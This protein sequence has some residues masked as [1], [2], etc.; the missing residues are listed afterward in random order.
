[1]MRFAIALLLV[2]GATAPAMADVFALTN[3]RV[4]T[5]DALG[6]LEDAT[7]LVRNGR[8]ASVG[9]DVR[10]PSDAVR[11][12]AAG[13]EVT[14]GLFAGFTNLG[15]Q[16]ISAVPETVDQSLEDFDRGAGFSIRRAVNP[17]SMLIG[18]ARTGGVTRAMIGPSGGSQVFAGQASLIRLDGASNPV[19]HPDHAQ[20]A[21]LGSRGGQRTGG[22]RAAALQQLEQGFAEALLYADSRALIRGAQASSLGFSR[23]D[24]DALLA[25]IGS[26]RPMA[27]HADRASDIIQALD[28][29]KARGI[30][31]VLLGGAEAWKV[32]AALAAAD[33]P[34]LLDPLDNLPRGFDRLGARS[35]NITL[36]HQAGVSV[37][38]LEGSGRDVRRIRQ[39]AG[40]AVAEGLPPE[41]A[42]A[43]ITRIPAEVWG[44]GDTYGRIAPGMSADLVLWN[45]DPLE[46]TTW[47]QRVWIEGREVPVDS[48]QLQLRDRYREPRS[49]Y[50]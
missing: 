16:E 27:V 28:I 19:S 23:W 6:T 4:H 7:V 8:I 25:F 13:G 33:V 24:L 17:D 40:N 29:L 12:D 5:V 18:V 35:D 44:V 42:L 20:V 46:L 11:I 10:I 22:S 37:G 38:I 32:A 39:Y 41:V 9:K 14:P 15:I 21:V 2:L 26:G 1:M 45:G 34:V 3:A 49:A 47:A 31:M 48:R 50:P 36:L 43:A 30:P